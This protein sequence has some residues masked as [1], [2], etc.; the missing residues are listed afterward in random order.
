MHRELERIKAK[1]IYI[2]IENGT[3]NA[4]DF[5]LSSYLGACIHKNPD[6]KY[7]IVSRDKGFDCVCHFWRDKSVL[8]KRINGFSFYSDINS[9]FI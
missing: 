3:P 7:Y 5:Q 6:H 1:K 9:E 2:E 4:L 8:V